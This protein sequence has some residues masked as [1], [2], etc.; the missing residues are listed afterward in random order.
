VSTDLLPPVT[1]PESNPEAVPVTVYSELRLA[2]RCCKCGAQAFV[3][4]VHPT[5][6]AHDGQL[7]RDLL[8][9]GHHFAQS[10][11]ALVAWTI[12]DERHKIN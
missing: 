3:R 2:D 12:Q 5:E 8:F 7:H 1:E 4:A 11:L 10:E 6:L 9:C